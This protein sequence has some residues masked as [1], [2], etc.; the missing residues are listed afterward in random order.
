ME[1]W[2]AEVLQ[3]GLMRYVPPD[4][5]DDPD[6]LAKVMADVCEGLRGTHRLRVVR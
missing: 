3:E 2:A 4:M 6:V 1:D 5:V